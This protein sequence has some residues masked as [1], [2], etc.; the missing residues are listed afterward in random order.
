MPHKNK[1]DRQVYQK[2]WYKQRRL[3]W[4]IENGPCFICFGSKLLEVHHVIPEQ[5]W[6]HSF[7]SYCRK[8]RDKELKKC[9]VLCRKCH[10]KITDEHLLG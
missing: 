9:I 7:W 10:R 1:Q 5:K 4:V 8:K 3:D 2:N 6:K